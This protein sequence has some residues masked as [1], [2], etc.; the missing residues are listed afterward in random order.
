M[1]PH[2]VARLSE[3]EAAQPSFVPDLLASMT[4]TDLLLLRVKM[5]GWIAPEIEA[6]LDRRATGDFP[7][8]TSPLSGES[9]FRIRRSHHHRRRSP[10]A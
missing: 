8:P 2:R 10:A 5:G 6:E 1:N 7:R 4:G 3:S 9:P